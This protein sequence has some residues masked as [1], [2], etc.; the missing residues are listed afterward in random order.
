MSDSDFS[1]EEREEAKAKFKR[2]FVGVILFII[3]VVVILLS[4]GR[5]ALA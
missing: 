1:P 5:G 3:F 2:L 4:T